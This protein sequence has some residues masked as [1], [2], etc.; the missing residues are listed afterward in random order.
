V[1]YT[2]DPPLGC[3]AS[4]QKAE[5][6]EPLYNLDAYQML[7]IV[8]MCYKLYAMRLSLPSTDTLHYVS[9]YGLFSTYVYHSDDV[10]GEK[11]D[12]T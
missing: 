11:S 10:A 3:A 9:A 1:T 8:A 7:A 6:C 2:L 5:L 12:A 4:W